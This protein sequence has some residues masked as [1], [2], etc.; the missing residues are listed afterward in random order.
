VTSRGNAREDIFD[1][2]QGRGLLLEFPAT[3]V[4]CLTGSATLT[5]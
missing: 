2:D 5:V 1:D 4:H 3:V